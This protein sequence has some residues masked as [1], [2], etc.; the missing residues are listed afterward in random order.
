M[1][2]Q[3]DLL[4]QAQL[5]M[6]ALNQLNQSDTKFVQPQKDEP[7]KKEE[8]WF[9]VESPANNLELPTKPQ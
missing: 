2:S 8:E 9:I 4:K 7:V 6:D 5:Q 3:D 1:E